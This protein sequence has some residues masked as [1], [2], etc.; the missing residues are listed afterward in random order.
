MLPPFHRQRRQAAAERARPR[1]TRR[2]TRK[3]DSMD[4]GIEGKRALVLGA[5]KGLGYAV[6]HALAA[7]GVV[8]AV[9]SS[10]I[11][12]A[13]EAA[14][15]I[16]KETGTKT[17]AV[18]GDVSNPDNMNALAEK[19]TA[20][21]GGVDILVNNHGG[22]P[23]GFATEMKEADLVDQ[24]NK[25]VVS[26]TRITGLLVP[27]MVAQ[28]WGRV[29]TIGSSGNVEPLPNMVLSNTLRAAIVSYMKTLANEVAKDGVTV[30]MVS[31]GTILTDRSRSSTEANA[32]RR[33]ISY[34]DVMAERVKTIP[35]GRLGDPK[36][37][38]A[39]AA[40]LASMQASYCTG[41]IW[42]V[43]GGKIKSIL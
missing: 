37:F 28:K 18:V 4:L 27:A 2:I 26:I 40:F 6:A 23:L 11:G 22:P 35:A 32:K 15:T 42:R 43:D 31:P 3:E 1:K 12:R 41:S 21:L 8:V 5:S 24:F 30:N 39:V 16:G 7:E 17:M 19:V 9:S 13:E 36:E 25:M 38:G 29:L 33:G 20:G 10:S 34:D 14:G